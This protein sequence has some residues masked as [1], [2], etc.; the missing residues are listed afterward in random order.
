MSN[1]ENIIKWTSFPLVDYPAST[2]LLTVFLVVF[3]FLF[4]RITFVSWQMPLFFYIGMT[5]FLISLIPYF[6][7]TCYELAEEKIIIF[8]SFIRVEK[9]YDEFQSFYYDKKGIMLSTF[10][11]PNRLDSFR[12]QSLRFSKS[13]AEKD[14]VLKMLKDKIGKRNV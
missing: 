13:Q 1:N 4:Y 5:A 7:P 8:Y 9:K 14:K 12:G 11:K 2:L 10:L 3:S 6:I